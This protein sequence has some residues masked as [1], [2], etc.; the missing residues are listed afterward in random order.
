FRR[1]ALPI[2]EIAVRPDHCWP[3][4]TMY[5]A[6]A[7]GLEPATYGFGDRCATNCATPLRSNN[8]NPWDPVTVQPRETSIPCPTVVRRTGGR[9]GGTSVSSLTHRLSLPGYVLMGLGHQRQGLGEA[10]PR[11]DVHLHLRRGGDDLHVDRPL[12]GIVDADDAPLRVHLQRPRS[13][14]IRKRAPGRGAE[15]AD[16]GAEGLGADPAVPVSAQSVV[17]ASGSQARGTHSGIV[18]EHDVEVRLA[19]FVSQPL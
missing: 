11:I 3:G 5:L 9:T 1:G 10:H 7:T 15:V 17:G 6:G 16:S 4:L 12:R 8:S 19:G 2:F 13:Q 14:R 18:D